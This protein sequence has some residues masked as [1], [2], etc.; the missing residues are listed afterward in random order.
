MEEDSFEFHEEA[1]ENISYNSSESSE[2]I[3]HDEE[4]LFANPSLSIVPSQ[5]HEILPLPQ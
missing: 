1:D 4:G 3:Y 2:N 5:Q